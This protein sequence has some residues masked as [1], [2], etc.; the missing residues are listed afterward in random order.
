[1]IDSS[2][3]PSNGLFAGLMHIFLRV[4]SHRLKYEFKTSMIR[5]H[6]VIYNN[7]L[8]SILSDPINE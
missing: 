2:D 7:S 3:K 5:Y 8:F 6:V 1:M 4:D